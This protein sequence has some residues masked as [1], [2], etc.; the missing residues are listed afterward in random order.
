MK[1]AHDMNGWQ[2]MKRAKTLALM[3]DLVLLASVATGLAA[4]PRRTIAISNQEA[5]GT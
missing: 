2:P 3:V 5:G 1:S 4:A